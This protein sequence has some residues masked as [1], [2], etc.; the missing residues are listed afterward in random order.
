[1]FES[2]S[3]SLGVI[4]LILGLVFIVL[5]YG[6]LRYVPRLRPHV[7]SAGTHLVPEIPA[8]SDAV[9]VVQPGG[10][11]S[12]INHEARQWF[13]LWEEEPNLERMARRARPGDVFLSLCA[14]E[15]NARFS[16]N[17]RLVEG[18]SYFLPNGDG[19]NILLS[20]RVPQVTALGDGEI[21]RSNQAL[22]ILTELNQSMA[23]N[24]DLEATLQSILTSVEQLIPTDFAEITTWDTDNKCLIPYR[25]IGLTGIDRRLEKTEDRYPMGEG[26]SGYIASQREPLLISDVENYREMR[27]IIDRS[28][29]PFRSFIGV[30]L[31]IGGNLIGTLELTSLSTNAYTENDVEILRMLSGQAAIALHNALLYQEEQRRARELSSLANLAQAAGSIRDSKELFAQLVQGITPLLDLEIAGF[32]IYDETRRTLT[33]Q[34]PFIGVPPQ[35]VEMYSTSIE[36][37]S[38]AEDIWVKQENIVAPNA[39]EDSRLIALGLDHPAR[40]AGIRD[41]ALIPLTSGGRSLGYL[42]AANKKDGTPFD[43]DDLRLLAIIAGQAA[44]IIENANLI[45]QSVQRALRAESLRRIASLTGSV[46]TIDEILK[47]S[48]L[49]LARLLQADIAAIYILDEGLGELRLHQES[50]YGTPQELSTPVIRISTNHPEYRYT[51]TNSRNTFITDDTHQDARILDLYRPI[52]EA[53]EIRSAIGVPLVVR[54]WGLGEII[55]GSQRTS[56]FTRNDIQLAITVASQLAISLER[57][58]LA[59]Q[60]DEDLRRRVEQL[61]ALTRIGRE[62]NTSTELEYLLQRVFDEALQ[63]TRA[64]CGNIVLFEPDESQLRPPRVML[65]LGD[66]TSDQLHPLERAVVEQGDPILIEDFSDPPSTYD[67]D[68]L[69]PAHEG[70]RSALIVPIAFQE[71][72]AGLIHLHGKTPGRF[73]NVALEITQALA[74]QAAIALGNAQ[75]YQELTQRNQILGRRLETLANLSEATREL[76]LEQS[77]ENTLEDIAYGIQGSTPFDVVLISLY[78]TEDKCLHR[79]TGAG[80]PLATLNE[81]IEQP[82]PWQLVQAILQPRFRIG[83]TY[84][85]PYEKMPTIPEQ[86]HVVTFTSDY[87][88]ELHEN[89]WNQR[90]SLLIPLLNASDE[91]LGLINV[92]SP[93]DNLRPDLPTIETLEIFASQAALAIE[94]K[95]RLAELETQMEGIRVASAKSLAPEQTEKLQNRLNAA[96]GIT[97]SINQQPDRQAVLRIVSETLLTHMGLDIVLVAEPGPAGPQL[98]HILGEVSEGIQPEALLGRRNPIHQTFQDR[99]TLIVLDLAG[100]D[101]WDDS[102]LLTAFQTRGFV[103]LPIISPNKTE[104]VI[105]A[106]SKKPLPSTTTEDHKLFSL[107]SS[108]AAGAIYNLDMITETSMRMR[109]VDLLL[110]FGAK[111]GSL[112]PTSILNTLIESALEVVRP[113]EAV[114]VA[115]LDPDQNRL[116]PHAAKGYTKNEALLKISYKPGEALLGQVFESGQVKRID[117]LDFARHYNLILDDLLQYRDATGGRLPVSSMVTPIQAGENK[118]GVLVLDNFRIPAAFSDEDQA[119][120]TSLA[121]Q[122]ALTLDN[123]QLFQA[124]EGRAAQLE[125]LSNVAATI[126]SSLETEA[127]IQS[128]LATLETVVPYNAGTLWLRDKNQL[129]IQSARGFDDSESLVGISTTVEDSRLFHEMIETGQPNF[130]EDI[131]NDPRFPSGIDQP[132]LSWLGVPLIA[133]GEVIGVIALEKNEPQFYTTE[134]IQAA[135]TFAS[136]ATVA[137]ENANL[138]QQSLQRAIEL[139]QRSQRQALLNRFSNQISGTMDPDR[140]INTTIQELQNALNASTISALLWR[141][142]DDADEDSGNII[143]QAEYPAVRDDLPAPLPMAPVFGYLRQ[144]LGVFNTQDVTN[145]DDLKPLSEFFKMRGTQAVLILTMAIGD[146]LEGFLLAHSNLPYHFSADEIELAR[147]I[148]NQAAVVIQNAILFAETQRLTEELEQRVADRTEQLGREHKRAQTLLNIMQELSASLDLDQVLNQTL[149]LLNESIGA[150]QSSILLLRPDELTYFYRAA[151]GFTTPPPRGGKPTVLE[152]GQGLA[153]WVIRHREGTIVYDLKQDERWLDFEDKP[154]KHR[155]AI[156]APLMV[157]AEALGA[158]MLFHREV[159]AFSEDQRDLVQAAANQMAVAINNAELFNLIREQAESLGNLLRT[160]QIEASRSRAILEAVADGV[161]V[162]D[163]FNMITLFNE[164]AQNTLDLDR[165]QV[166]DKSLEEFIGL[167]GS[168]AQPWMDTIQSWSADPSRYQLG[169]MYAEQIT[170]DN[171]RVVSIHLAPVIFRNEFLGTVSIFRDITHLIELDRLKSEF[172]ATVSHELRTP[173]TSIKGY[174][175]ILL[176]GAAGTLSE[177]QSQFLNIVKINTERLNVLVNDLLDISRIEAGKI[178]LSIQALDFKQITEEIIQDLQRQSEK[179]QKPITVEA[180]IPPDLPRVQGDLERVRQILANIVNNSYH[181]TSSDGL[182]IIRAEQVENEVLIEVKDNGI[183]IPL[184][185]QSRVF[186]RFFRGEDPMVLTTSGTGLGLSI[187]KELVEMHHGRIWLESD[188][189]PGKGSKFYFT[190]PIHV[191]DLE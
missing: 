89:S 122:A 189:V 149:L 56:T 53:F 17:G 113:A 169:D 186:E 29:Y 69:Q 116:I 173:M 170:L 91:P 182:I 86:L 68:T 123:I 38:P 111:L 34:N 80:I 13:E 87:D 71:H 190:L 124:A 101:T 129:I 97:E 99:E 139:D 3:A 18:T 55:V 10:R 108:Q 40:A 184:E 9:L 134:H 33:A 145:E 95:S 102:P 107:L 28:K 148:T 70:V 57:S 31:V 147:I 12:Y 152:V 27:P 191:P 118:F 144:S 30:P 22:D 176:M 46:A 5:T 163:A 177:Q 58:S 174:V 60:T 105:L 120:I 67:E 156:C 65:A 121:Q 168:A 32:L 155:S 100:D 136:Q 103:C 61:T 126:T 49:E 45:Q 171:N 106:I 77:I 185:D 7:Q 16:L 187:V 24:L 6:L 37:D 23:R 15:G 159:N 88:G 1:M 162:T 109:E 66:S 94:S 76:H 119:L 166:V 115:L 164:S 154:S 44:P 52:I 21:D 128:L 25:F 165:E 127:L 160:Q 26:Y 47:Y 178:D 73:D 110:D 43:Q 180:A 84:F 59:S 75:R 42:Q 39:T 81:L 63:T 132:R 8:H 54:E 140:L 158:M 157:G 74:I 112:E 35:F 141:E 14:T 153:G 92:A 96:L 62:L 133:K 48:L 142:N 146:E 150:E 135:T 98:I 104:A 138:Y 151:L 19:K 93:R 161:L 4:L 181:Y 114:M 130:V 50:L 64:N 90:D 85:I 183:G 41:T 131:R 79:V 137:L 2:G 125:A 175:D 167:F 117:E 83:R 51:I 78:H 172:V 11:V 179:D 20:L 72:I 143:L 188:G 36:T 82:Q